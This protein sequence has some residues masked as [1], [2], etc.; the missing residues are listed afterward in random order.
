MAQDT[1]T[2]LNVA[3][4]DCFGKK[5]RALRREGVIPANIYGNA[6]DSVAVQVPAD[7]LRHLM[8]AHGRTEIVYVQLDGEERPTFIKDLQRNPVTDQVLHVD[9]MQISLK[10][11]VKIEVPV[12]FVGEA[13]A[14][15]AHGGIVTHHLNQVLVEALPTSI[16]SA[17]EVDISGLAEIGQSLHVSDIVVPEGVVILTDLESALARID[18]PAAERAEE[19]E[20]AEAE[21]DEGAEEGAPEAAVAE[22]AAESS[23]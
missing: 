6:V 12:H 8:R 1:K 4:R 10:E 20:E 14:V 7:D 13:P 9:F 15:D 16:P 22:E 5:V 23:E 11:K 3:R 19:V 17:L 21:G 2:V 18:L